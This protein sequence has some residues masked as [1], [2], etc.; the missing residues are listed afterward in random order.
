[1]ARLHQI[2]IKRAHRGTMDGAERAMLV[3]GRGIAGDANQGGTRPVTLIDLGR[4]TEFM[5]RS[6]AELDT[7]AR[8]ANLVVDGLDLFDSRGR[9]LRIGATR[10][11]IRGETR[12]CERMDE[13]LPGL[14]SAMGER[15]GGGAFAEVVEGGEISVGDDVSWDLTQGEAGEG[16]GGRAVSGNRR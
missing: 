14:Q 15:W 9:T 3:A 4:W 16:E 10:L 1:M 13:A 11:I 12:P 7:S 8:R 2:W 6:G 5:D